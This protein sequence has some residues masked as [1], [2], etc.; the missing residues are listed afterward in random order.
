M[1]EHKTI[2]RSKNL[3]ITSSDSKTILWSGRIKEFH[4]LR[5]IIGR[6]LNCPKYAGYIES[7][8]DRSGHEIKCKKL[9][10]HDGVALTIQFNYLLEQINQPSEI[11]NQVVKEISDLVHR[12]SKMALLFYH[13]D[14]EGEWTS[15]ECGQVKEILEDIKWNYKIDKENQIRGLMLGLNYCLQRDLKAHFRLTST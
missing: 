13:S 8:I 6:K 9:D 1:S 14:S 3:V 12:D 4:L 11:P 7:T 2:H 15:K 10:R 5:G